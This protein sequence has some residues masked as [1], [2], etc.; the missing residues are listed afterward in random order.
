M[1][2]PTFCVGTASDMP[3]L[4]AGAPGRLGPLDTLGMPELIGVALPVLDHHFPSEP[5]VPQHGAG[6]GQVAVKGNIVV[7][8]QERAIMND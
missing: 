1:A 4:P 5:W 7:V 3:P 8:S 6:P 2:P